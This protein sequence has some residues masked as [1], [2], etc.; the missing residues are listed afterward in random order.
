MKKEICLP[1]CRRTDAP[2]QG[3][4]CTVLWRER[5]G[6]VWKLRERMGALSGSPSRRVPRV[7]AAEAGTSGTRRITLKSLELILKGTGVFIINSLPSFI[8]PA[9]H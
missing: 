4:S 6:Q 3:N 9:S 5:A 2:T 1:R 7:E 8:R